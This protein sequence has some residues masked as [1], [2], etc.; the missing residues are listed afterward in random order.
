MSLDLSR[1]PANQRTSVK[2]EVGEFIVDQILSSVSNAKSPVEGKGLFKSLSKQYA[3]N[4]KGGNRKA[5]LELEGDMLDS[6]EF[7]TTTAGVDIG[8]FEKDEAIKAFNHN[9]GD[10][11]PQRQF[12]PDTTES[13]SKGIQAGVNS[14]IK[15]SEVERETATPTRGVSTEVTIDSLFGDVFSDLFGGALG[16]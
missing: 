5:N 14:I 9:T 11:L 3:D 15:D 13:F 7:K 1:V 2:N 8:I 10:T 12:I 16:S 4:Q 6:L